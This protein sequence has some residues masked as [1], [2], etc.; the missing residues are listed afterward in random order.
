VGD[1]STDADTLIMP[2]EADGAVAGSSP[3]GAIL[4]WGCFAST[5]HMF[6]ERDAV[7]K[8]VNFVDKACL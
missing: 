4:H 5:P 1:T 7:G 2:A 8:I 6:V 3:R